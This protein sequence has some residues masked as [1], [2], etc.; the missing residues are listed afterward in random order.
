MSILKNKKIILA[1]S[2][3]I[4]AYKAAF[5]I[6]LLTKSGADLRVIMTSAAAD[7]ISPLTLSTLS[8][9]QVLNSVSSEEGWNNHVELG[10]WADAMIIAPAT[11]NTLA[12]LANGLCNNMVLAVYLSARCPVFFAPAMDLDMWAHPSTQ[13]NVQK[14]LSYGNILIDVADGELASGLSGKG[15]MAEPEDIVKSL[16]NYF[17]I[18]AYKPLTGKKVLITSGPTLEA[19]DPVRFISN[20]STGKMGK[21]IAETMADAGAEVVFVSGPVNEYPQHINIKTIKVKSAEEMY[22]AAL[23]EFA[24]AT[25]SILTAAVA[26]YSPALVATEK[27]KKKG[28]E[29]MVIELVKTIDIAAALGKL[30]KENQLM[31]GF[32]LETENFMENALK[33]LASKNLDFIVLNSLKDEGA[34]FGFDTNKI[35][36]IDRN[37]TVEKFE[38]KSKKAV[39]FDILKKISSFLHL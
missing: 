21:A 37:K 2:G 30:K 20:H 29:G 32:A 6:R 3:S 31:V 7:F 23:S 22:K 4:A 26:D 16:E 28:D 27:I 8:K 24:D 13:N 17:E 15:R 36:I 18:N 1:V 38:L 39:A 12:G 19:I 10:L 34:G 33:K 25:I 11:A 9:N 35:T 14:L 5:L